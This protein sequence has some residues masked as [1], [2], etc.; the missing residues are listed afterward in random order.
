MLKRSALAAVLVGAAFGAL[1]AGR[2]VLLLMVLTVSIVA[3]GET[4]RMFRIRGAEPAVLLGLAG[5]VALLGV[6]HGRGERAPA[7]FPFVLAA[8]LG[9]AFVAMLSRRDRTDVTRVVAFTLLPTVA[10]GLLAS[11][12]IVL[13]AEGG[14][15]RAV[16]GFLLMA[17]AAQLG[18]SFVVALR[19]R[20]ERLSYSSWGLYAGALVP[21][22]VSA[23]IVASA[24]RPPFTW[25]RAL[26]LA[27]LV[28]GAVGGGK[29]A[30]DV[31]SRDLVGSEGAANEL[32]VL[33]SIDGVLLA[34]PIFFYA[35][36]LLAR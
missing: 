19:I 12:V 16:L 33:R 4:F 8:V 28:A 35:F 7:V 1:A 29:H 6:A 30:W 36:R 20:R 10:I 32:S 13:R 27:L 21:T 5:I 2:I 22:L 24:I 23:A 9:A 31:I 14:G 11:Y 18:V 34:A 25:P 15:F 3:A 17:A 26:V